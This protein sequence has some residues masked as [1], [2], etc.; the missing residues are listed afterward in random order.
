MNSARTFDTIS[1]MY[2]SLPENSNQVSS[3]I[4]LKL[5]ATITSTKLNLIQWF[6]VFIR[7]VEYRLNVGKITTEI[8][9]A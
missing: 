1:A 5:I 9:I 4:L 8:H 3:F 2:G 6:Y 7:I